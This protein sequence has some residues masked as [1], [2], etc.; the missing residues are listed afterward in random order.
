MREIIIRS[1]IIIVSI[2]LQVSFLDLVFTRN[3]TFE[4]L[5][6]IALAWTIIASFEK[7]WPW[8]VALGVL[9]DMIMFERVGVHVIFF[10][11][12]A[13]LISFFSRRFLIEKKI[14]GFIVITSFIVI[15]FLALDISRILIAE[16]FSF[17]NAYGIIGNDVFCVHKIVN[18][19]ILNILL[20][21]AVYWFLNKVEKS[22]ERYKN[23]TEIIS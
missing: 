11:A 21:Y 13:Y 8:I 16:N 22:I 3:L 5:P 23:K 4:L 2:V 15:I 19:N 6:L 18:Q 12:V 14:S 7:I 9:S 17:G 10:I 20:F 1:G